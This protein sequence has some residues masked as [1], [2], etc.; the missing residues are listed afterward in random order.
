MC[1]VKAGFFDDIIIFVR[2]RPA[3]PHPFGPLKPL[4]AI[5]FI[6]E[7]WNSFPP[8]TGSAKRIA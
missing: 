5:S 4:S 8:K 2:L 3:P 7:K 1:G 6:L